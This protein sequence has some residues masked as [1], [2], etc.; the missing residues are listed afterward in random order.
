MVTDHFS[1]TSKGS[2]SRF[3]GRRREGRRSQ[4]R[5]RSCATL[6]SSAIVRAPRASLPAHTPLA[7]PP[8]LTL[9]APFKSLVPPSRHTQHD[10][11]GCISTVLTGAWC[12]GMATCPRAQKATLSVTRSS[13]L[14]LTLTLTLTHRLS[15]SPSPSHFTL[16]LTLHPHPHT[17]PSPT[18]NIERNKEL[19]RQLGLA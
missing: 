19:L 6:S 5:R 13:C 14:T 17:S 18:G 16:A 4:R 12:M 9:P 2:R 7:C 8:P 10:A 15:P 3:S 1:G 11:D